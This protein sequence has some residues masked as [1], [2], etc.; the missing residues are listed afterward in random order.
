MKP[1]FPRNNLLNFPYSWPSKRK[2]KGF[3][4]TPCSQTFLC[5]NRPCSSKALQLSEG[6]TPSFDNTDQEKA[7]SH[8]KV[9]V[10]KMATKLSFSLT[11]TKN[12]SNQSKSYQISYLFF[13]QKKHYCNVVVNMKT[14]A[15]HNMK[16]V[17][18]YRLSLDSGKS[19]KVWSNEEVTHL[20]R[21]DLGRTKG[22]LLVPW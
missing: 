5:T 18:D 14:C 6:N 1:N 3:T 7:V 17:P 8:K 2:A 22:H 4:W 20:L 19:I 16:R 15:R 21:T 12:S 11:S 10:L 13:K 9:C